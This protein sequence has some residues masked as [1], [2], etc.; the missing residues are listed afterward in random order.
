MGLVTGRG[1]LDTGFQRENEPGDH[2][3][4]ISWP[5]K[6]PPDWAG[7]WR[8]SLM[9]DGTLWTSSGPQPFG[10]REAVQ[11]IRAGLIVPYHVI[12]IFAPPNREVKGQPSLHLRVYHFNT[13]EFRWMGFTH[14]DHWRRAAKAKP[15]PPNEFMDP[16]EPGDPSVTFH[17]RTQARGDLPTDWK[18][19]AYRV[20]FYGTFQ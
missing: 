8:V 9:A 10:C 13:N 17:F 5:Y 20:D 6:L 18:I 2:A 14:F 1:R 7:G 16:P 12:L 19:A 4:P 15:K 11:V 3:R